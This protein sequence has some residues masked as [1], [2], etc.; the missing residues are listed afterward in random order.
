MIHNGLI[1][2]KQNM[3]IITKAKNSLFVLSFHT[4]FMFCI[5]CIC[6]STMYTSTFSLIKI[7]NI[8]QVDIFLFFS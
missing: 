5:V 7:L 3:Q 2:D 4:V 6:T 1:M 8:L